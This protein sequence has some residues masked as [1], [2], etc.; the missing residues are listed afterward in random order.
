M[1][2]TADALRV[3]NDFTRSPQQLTPG[4]ANEKADQGFSTK[5][6]AL[7]QHG[8]DP[9]PEGSR[10]YREVHVNSDFWADRAIMYLQRDA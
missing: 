1:T 5:S 4:D 8:P 9:A 6:T 3:N 7:K 10:A 2:A